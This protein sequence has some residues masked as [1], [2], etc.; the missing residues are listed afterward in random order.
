[1]I[2]KKFLRS[3]LVVAALL[4]CQP[5]AKHDVPSSGDGGDTSDGGVVH[6]NDI[7]DAGLPDSGP[8]PPPKFRAVYAGG[9]HTCGLTAGGGMMCWGL[10]DRGQL[11]DNST[12]DRHLPVDVIGLT[13]GVIA[14]ATGDNHTCAIKGSVLLCWG[15]GD[16]GKLGDSTTADH[17]VPVSLLGLSGATEIS[18]GENHTC[19]TTSVGGVKCWGFN[20][21][22]QIGDGTSGADF[23][24]GTPQERDVPVDVVGLALVTSVAAGEWNSCAVANG[25][26]KCWG[27]NGF[28]QLG[29]NSSLRSA[30]PVDVVGL[31]SGVTAMAMSPLG[32]HRAC[33]TTT[34]GVECW[35]ENRAGELGN[36]TT[37]P[38]AVPVDVAEL[39]SGVTALVM[40][41]SHACVLVGGRV[42]CWGA[43]ESGQLGDNSTANSFIPVAAVGV[44]AATAIAAGSAHSCAV[45]SQG[46][47]RCWGSNAFGQLGDNTTVDHPVPSDIQF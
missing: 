39:T 14:V 45:T 5:D 22:G 17:A 8:L 1:M 29:N 23:P 27:E 11:G 19:A 28:G 2:R 15:A 12:T 40:G 10:N 9:S 13:A 38:S 43:N 20:H 34:R 33:A 44:T 16:S 47:V 42:R 35:G 24:P 41:A 37:T 6:P 25:G 18:A 31:L 46:D 3:G 32:S 26:A 36:N 7:N 30:V 4:G 21:D